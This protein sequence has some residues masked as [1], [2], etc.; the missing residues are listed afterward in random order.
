MSKAK[1]KKFDAVKMMREI[2]EKLSRQY[3]VNPEKQSEDL[4]NI[5]K[6]YGVKSKYS[7]KVKWLFFFIGFRKLFGIIW[8]QTQ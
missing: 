7:R 3:E 4:E 8:N 2:R 5:R 6:K 1:V